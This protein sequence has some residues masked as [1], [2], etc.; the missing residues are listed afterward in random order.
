MV[1]RARRVP[2]DKSEGIVKG[3]VLLGGAWAPLVCQR[4]WGP[5]LWKS[6]RES[7]C[8]GHRFHQPSIRP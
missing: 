2:L 1:V 7:L 4:G 6:H 8:G 3:I 5:R